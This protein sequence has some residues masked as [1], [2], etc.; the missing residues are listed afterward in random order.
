MV[1]GERPRRKRSPASPPRVSRAVLEETGRPRDKGEEGVR[2]KD[3]EEESGRP[4]GR[5][6]CCLDE[7]KRREGGRSGS[8]RPGGSE[9]Y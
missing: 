8:G 1:D 3:W 2:L 7:E 6:A 5:R 4:I 9:A